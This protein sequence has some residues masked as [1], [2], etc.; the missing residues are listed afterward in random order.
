MKC[1]CLPKRQFFVKLDLGS[2][3]SGDFNATQLEL[4]HGVLNPARISVKRLSAHQKLPIA[5]YYPVS[6]SAINS[7]LRRIDLTFRWVTSSPGPSSWLCTKSVQALVQLGR[8]QTALGT[9]WFE[10]Y[11]N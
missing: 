7:K 11:T 8:L 4:E 3:C 2:K 6:L 5:V 9:V 10:Q 1:K